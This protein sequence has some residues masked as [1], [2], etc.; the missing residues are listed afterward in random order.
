MRLPPLPAPPLDPPSTEG[1]P[2]RLAAAAADC[3]RSLNGPDPY[4]T[5]KKITWTIS[6]TGCAAAPTP[7][8]PPPPDARRHRC[9]YVGGDGGSMGAGSKQ[10]PVWSTY[11]LTRRQKS[12]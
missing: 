6:N 4:N 8:P 7:A 9:R 12:L 10:Q 3:A 1:L 11:A 5:G 2:L